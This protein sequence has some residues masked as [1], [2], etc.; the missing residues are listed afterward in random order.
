MESLEAGLLK[1]PEILARNWRCPLP[2]QLCGWSPQGW[3][4]VL[5]ELG[6]VI[7]WRLR[8]FAHGELL[9]DSVLFCPAEQ[10]TALAFD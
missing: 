2:T 10:T 6:Q 5:G 7:I 3:C 9:P 4:G 8:G 1:M